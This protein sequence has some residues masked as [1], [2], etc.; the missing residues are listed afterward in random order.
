MTTN[1]IAPNELLPL[2]LCCASTLGIA[3]FAVMR[4][5][6]GDWVIG[7]I[8][9]LIVISMASLGVFV[10]RTHKVR[11]A[12]IYIAI[13][14]VMGALVTVYLK[15][16]M[17]VL[18]SY[19]AMIVAFYILKPKEAALLATLAICALVPPLLKEMSYSMVCAV[20]VTQFISSAVA[21]AFAQ[22]TMRQREML[23]RLA[24]RDPLTGAGNRRALDEELDRVVENNKR[25]GTAASILLLDL[26]RFKQIND[27]FG[28][29]VGDDVLNCVSKIIMDRIRKT[30]GLYRIGGEEFVVVV[31][32]DKLNMALQLAE[33]LRAQIEVCRDVN[34]ISITVSI[35]IAELG[36]NETPKKWLNRA[37]E[38]LYKAKRT[39][40]NR[41]CA[42]PVP[43]ARPTLTTV[44][45][46][47]P[48]A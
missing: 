21:F 18:W 17:Q 28:H 45:N 2:F 9:T 34:D 10:F 26:D 38:A 29:S 15:G 44:V 41:T 32:N 37:D 31:N 24:T 42:A 8:D 46:N 4:F 7:I 35:G 47:S 19:P 43:G 1:R 3:P 23:V 13:L 40:R 16:A 14:C 11:S 5:A 22:Q 36:A 25:A 33:S 20:L 6:S 12:S 30:D 39:G 48:A 27:Q